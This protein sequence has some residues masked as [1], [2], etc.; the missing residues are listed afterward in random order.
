M[1]ILGG[2]DTRNFA[3]AIVRRRSS[4]S[5]GSTECLGVCIVEAAELSCKAC[6]GHHTIQR[7]FLI[8]DSSFE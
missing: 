6:K 7:C 8:A 2:F 3:F 4:D 1:D 5:I